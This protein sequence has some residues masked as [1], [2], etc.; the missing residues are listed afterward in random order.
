M[1]QQNTPTTVAYYRVANRSQLTIY[2]GAR[3]RYFL[4]T[5]P[6]EEC[7]LVKHAKSPNTFEVSCL[8][9]LTPLGRKDF[10]KLLNASIGEVHFTDTATELYLEG[11]PVAEF[12][13]FI[14]SYEANRRIEQLLG[15]GL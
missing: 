5:K 8:R 4:D 6:T 2:E 3:L 14:D 13:R 9:K 1:S 10:S 12:E 11:L 15:M 7:L